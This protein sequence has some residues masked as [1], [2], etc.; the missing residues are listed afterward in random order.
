MPEEM[1][2]RPGRLERHT[3]HQRLRETQRRKVEITNCLS[4]MLWALHRE[5]QQRKVEITI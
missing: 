3:G 2:S 4:L 5:T 1:A